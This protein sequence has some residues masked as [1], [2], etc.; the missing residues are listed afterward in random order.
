MDAHFPIHLA[1]GEIIRNQ[2][3]ADLA[4]H[5]LATQKLVERDCLKIALIDRQIAEIERVLGSDN[6]QN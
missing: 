3:E 1:D 2:R 4:I 5:A 6:R